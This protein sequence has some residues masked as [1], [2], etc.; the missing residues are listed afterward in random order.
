[1]IF[2]YLSHV[3]YLIPRGDLVVIDADQ[4]ARRLVLPRA[5]MLPTVH[6]YALRAHRAHGVVPTGQIGYKYHF[7][8]T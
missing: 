4:R 3:C 2:L 6:K 1:M 5:E 8:S 7:V